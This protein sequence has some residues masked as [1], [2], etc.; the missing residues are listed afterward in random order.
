MAHA[1]SATLAEI[2]DIRRLTA[3]TRAGFK[4]GFRRANHS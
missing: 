2:K 4:V 1:G 3:D